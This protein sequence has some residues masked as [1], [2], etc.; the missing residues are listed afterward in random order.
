M[1]V[2]RG[3]RKLREPPFLL[4]RTISHSDPLSN[5]PNAKTAAK[6]VGFRGSSSACLSSDSG[7]LRQHRQLAFRPMGRGVLWTGMK[8]I[9]LRTTLRLLPAALALATAIPGLAE[10]PPAI[11]PK[12]LV[13]RAVANEMKT[14]AGGA[15][16]M[17]RQRKETP[18]GS[19]TKLMV[20]T[21]DAMVGMVVANN[22]Q[23]LSQEER[24]AEYGRIER[25]LHDPAEL[26][27]KRTKEKESAER[28]NRILRALPDAFLFEYDGTETGRPGLGKPGDQ[29]VRLKFRPDPSYDPPTHVEQVLVGMEGVVL[30]DAQKQHIA[31]IDGTLFK[32]VGFGW[33]ILGHLDRGGHFQVDQADI[34]DDN[35]AISRMDL[36]FTGKI[37]LFKSINIKSTEIYSDFHPVPAD[38]TFAQGIQLL[39]HQ[40]AAIAENQPPGGHK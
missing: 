7:Y 14:D 28:V 18:S 22:G 24:R 21:R 20:E 32:E 30:I 40:Q 34:S 3:P 36:A 5:R 12:E 4:Y 8:P 25:F 16:Y 9:L 27:R 37:L 39:K 26:E 13:R 35:W 38:L 10:G 17:F 11:K 23:P 6:P 15:K 29:L 1:L 31:R 2:E 33:G 19:Q